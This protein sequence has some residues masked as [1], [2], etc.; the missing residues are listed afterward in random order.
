[1]PDPRPLPIVW[2]LDAPTVKGLQSQDTRSAKKPKKLD[3]ILKL[4]I[5][6]D[7]GGDLGTLRQEIEAIINEEV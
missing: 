3:R 4:L 5:K 7:E 1:M 6:F 2:Y